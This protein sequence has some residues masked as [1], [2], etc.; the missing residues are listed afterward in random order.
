MPPTLPNVRVLR[1]SFSALAARDDLGVWHG[2]TNCRSPR[3]SL[4]SQRS[5]GT[6]R[7]MTPWTQAGRAA[8]T[9]FVRRASE[10]FGGRIRGMVLFGSV[11]RGTDGPDS[12]VDV[13]VLVND[14]RADLRD[15]LDAIAF[16]V[17]MESRRALVFTLYPALAYD[18]ARA[19][20]S[21]FA[22]AVER[23]GETLWTRNGEPSSALA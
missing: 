11:A 1:L 8:A 17:T 22:A 5:R 13:L 9:A 7:F 2:A 23:E 3:R 21:E 10:Q 12:D 16:D 14:T 20:G 15:G 19:A 4:S 18:A 6:R